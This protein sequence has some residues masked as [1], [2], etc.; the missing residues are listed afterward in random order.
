[1]DSLELWIQLTENTLENLHYRLHLQSST[2]L[3]AFSMQESE[4]RFLEYVWYLLKRKQ[5]K[6]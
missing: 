1:M 3:T 5:T 4:V 6:K 2:L